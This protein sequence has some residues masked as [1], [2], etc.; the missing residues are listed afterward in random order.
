MY[1]Y[2]RP[3]WSSGKL[4]SP[5]ANQEQTK[6]NPAQI[7]PG[8]EA[9]ASGNGTAGIMLCWEFSFSL[10]NECF[11][12]HSSGGEGVTLDDSQFLAPKFLA[13][14]GLGGCL[15]SPGAGPLGL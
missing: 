5:L 9:A 13:S 8:L 4:P 10:S 11:R 15:R 6:R 7:R 14:G 1:T 12:D 3:L 2:H